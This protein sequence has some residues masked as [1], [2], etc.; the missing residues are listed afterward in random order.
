MDFL[1]IEKVAEELRSNLIKERFAGVFKEEKLV[2]F[3]VGRFYL[4]F[5]WGNP[6]A[7]FL[8]NE[9]LAKQEF[10]P[11]MKLKGA[12][13]KSISLPAV[14]RVI[15]FMLV[16]PVTGNKLIRFFLIFELT[17]KNAN[18][19]LL[20]EHRKVEFLLRSVD[21]SVR[22]ISPGDPY[23]LPPSDKKKFE[24]L[25]FGEVTL[26]G[27][28]SKLYK[29]VAG[30]SPLNA[31]EIAYLMDKYGSLTKAYEE[32]MKLH[33]KSEKAFVYYR[34]GKPKFLTTFP[35]QSLSDLESK[36]FSGFLPYSS[37]WKEFYVKTVEEEKFKALKEKLVLRIEKKLNSLQKELQEF[38]N[39]EKLRNEAEKWKRMGELL[40]YNLHLV[41][42]GQNEVKVMDFSTGKEECVPL[43]P[44]L[45][46][47][48][49]LSRIFKKYR[50]LLKR[51]SFAENR[52]GEI[53]AEL[54]RLKLLKEFVASREKIE[55]LKALLPKSTKEVLIPDFLTFNLPSGKKIL[56]GRNATENEFLS[57]RLANPWDLWFHAKDIP[58]SHV[59]L[60]LQK[61]EEPSDEDILLSASAAAYFSKGKESGRVL[62]DYTRVKNLKKPPKTPK[63]FVIYSGEKTVSVSPDIFSEIFEE[64]SPQKGG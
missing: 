62:V 39:P 32:F 22:P 26:E 25:Q 17:G 34:N 33:R 58:G 28:K 2:S 19:F 44:L 37:A 64:K 1:Y 53:K 30:I 13:I 23:I 29:F 38:E 50:K 63:G 6:N 59:I 51:I 3:R 61:G 15:E 57:L 8:D 52:L 31:K 47:R 11:L 41:K 7:F 18:L 48:E 36:E 45:S 5:Y 49:N 43:D 10:P 20:N 54:E 35:Y 60:R 21:S 40:K 4:N 55:E 42:P 27:V 12:F 9:P 56:V 24:E 14:D 16:K 46:P